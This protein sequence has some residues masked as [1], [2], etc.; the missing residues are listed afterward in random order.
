MVDMILAK[1]LAVILASA[2]P[3]L[4]LRG[5][6]PLGIGMGLNPIWVFLTAVVV[7]CAV[8]FLI[9][10]GVNMFYKKYLLHWRFFKMIVERTR[11][12]G[13][14]YIVKYGIFGICMFVGV[15][16]P[17]TGLWTGTLLAWLLGL[18]W[19]RSFMAASLGVLMAGIIVTGISLGVITGYGILFGG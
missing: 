1:Y 6:I 11:Q 19:K 4:E 10:F 13:K 7:N 3:I 2:S 12:R 15:P 18:D 17:F 5:G 14:P 16:L 8:F 9:Y